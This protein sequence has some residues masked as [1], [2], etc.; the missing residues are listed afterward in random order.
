MKRDELV[1]HY[2]SGGHLGSA[3]PVSVSNVSVP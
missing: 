3:L 1:R 2:V